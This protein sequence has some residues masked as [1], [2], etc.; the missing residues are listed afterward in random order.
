MEMHWDIKDSDINRVKKVIK[1]QAEAQLVKA[2][3]QNLV[4]QRSEVGKEAFWCRMVKARLTTQNRVGPGAPVGI[5]VRKRPFPLSYERVERVRSK[6]NVERFIADTVEQAK[7]GKF[8]SIARD[9]AVNWSYL[10][11]GEWE[12]ALHECNRLTKLP[13]ET[14]EEERRKTERAAANYIEDTFSVRIS[15]GRGKGFGPKQSRNFL[16]MLGLT[17]Y[18]IPID[19]R[20]STWLN[21]CLSPVALTSPLLGDRAFYEFVLDGIQELCRQA[22]TVP[23]LFDASV[24]AA[25][26]QR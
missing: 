25:M 9:L 16:Q 5:F 1:D 19:S 20:L 13:A 2:R 15:K 26:E 12:Q 7:I 8:K 24:F 17:R 4:S 6:R 22:G 3:Q 18:E 23:C 14:D 21:P 10:K 11:S